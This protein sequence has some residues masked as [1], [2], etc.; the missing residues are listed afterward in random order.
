[1]AGIGTKIKEA[2]MKAAK[3]KMS[4]DKKGK[5]RTGGSESGADKAKGAIKNFL[6]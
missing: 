2:A 1:M 3:D 6:K 5:K 4:G